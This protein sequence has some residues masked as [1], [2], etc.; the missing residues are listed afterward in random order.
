[1]ESLIYAP[2]PPQDPNRNVTA[3]SRLLELWPGEGADPFLCTLQN[4]DIEHPHVPFEALSYVWGK[5]K[6]DNVLLC[7]DNQG[8]ILGQ[9][10]LT[11]NLEQALRGLRHPQ[12]RRI[13]WIDAICI[14]QD[15]N[16]ERSRQVS[17]M[18]SVY[19][20]ASRVIVWLGEKDAT[21][22]NAFE[23]AQKL[24]MT[25]AVLEANI[26]QGSQSP[27]Q[28]QAA[29][30]QR[31]ALVINAMKAHPEDSRALDALLTKEYFERVWCIQEVAAAKD[32]V[33]KCEDLEIDFGILL[34]VVPFVF[35][36]RGLTP[37]ASGLSLWQAMGMV[38]GEDHD[39]TNPLTPTGSL[40]PML[41]V[42]MS[43][44][45][46][47]ATN[48]VDRIYA[49]LGCT[50][51]GLEPILGSLNTFGGNKRNRKLA[52]MQRGM[53]WLAKNLEGQRRPDGKFLR[54]WALRPDYDKSVRDVY[55]DFTRYCIRRSP[56]VLDALSHVQH[57]SDPTGQDEFPTWVPKFYEPRNASSFVL[58][59]YM[60]GVPP[61]GHYRYF[62]HLQDSPLVQSS[63]KEPNV[64]QADGF[65][66]DVVA[67]VSDTITPGASETISPQTVWN[68]L[69]TMPLSPR[70]NFQY[71]FGPEALDVAFF[72]TL[73]AGG[74]LN[75]LEVGF[76]GAPTTRLEAVEHFTRQAKCDLY[77][78]L[79][80]EPS[81]EAQA[82]P[83][84]IR[85][86][87]GANLEQGRSRFEKCSV[88]YSFNRRLYRTRSGMLGLG[89]M[90][91]KPGDIVV[92]LFGGRYPFLLRQLASE[93]LFLGETYVRNNHI[94][95]GEAV[96]ENKIMTGTLDC[97]PR[98]KVEASADIAGNGVLVAFLLSALLTL[99]AVVFGYLSES[100]PE[101][102]FNEIDL[103]LVTQMHFK[104]KLDSLRSTLA[105]WKDKA[106]FR[107][108]PSPRR[109]KLSRGERQEALT[110]FIL[111]LSDQQLATGFAVLIG[112]IANHSSLTAYDFR[113]AFGLAWF[114]ATT[115]LATLD[116]LRDYFIF[117][118]TVR[119]WRIRGMVLILLLLFY[120]QFITLASPHDSVPM[121]C[122][123]DRPDTGVIAGANNTTG[124]A[125]QSNY[126]SPVSIS[127]VLT[128]FFMLITG[129]VTRIYWSRG[130]GADNVLLERI[131]FRW[132]Y[133]PSTFPEVFDM[134]TVDRT[135]LFR[136]FKLLQQSRRRRGQLERAGNCIGFRRAFY[137]Y[138][139]IMDIYDESFL[140]LAPPLIFMI[141]YGL[142]QLVFTRWMYP[143]PIVVDGGMSFGQITPLC[144][145][146]IPFLAAAETYYEAKTDNTT[147]ESQ[148]E[149]TAD[150]ATTSV[151]LPINPIRVDTIPVTLPTDDDAVKHLYRREH[152]YNEAVNS[153]KV[154]LHA[155]VNDIE[156]EWKSANLSTDLLA[157]L[158]KKDTLLCK[159]QVLEAFKRSLPIKMHS[160]IAFALNSVLC[161]TMG[162]LLNFPSQ[163]GL[164]GVI[165]SV[166][167]LFYYSSSVT[168]S[169]TYYMS[170]V[171]AMNKSSIM[172]A[173]EKIRKV[174]IAP[175]STSS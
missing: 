139:Y 164:T 143:L 37:N 137:V 55:R 152:D 102:Y 153:I 113:I 122:L 78:W 53:I 160:W 10:E 103:A 107:K 6:S 123:Y 42:L 24:V 13:L 69:F 45:N 99:G 174:P 12:Q 148:N 33:A 162:I 159:Y 71:E 115:H 56:R 166:M 131:V 66:V 31:Q 82:Y 109:R 172:G 158:Q 101:G 85:D 47:K 48:P 141:S 154:Y 46:F 22:R 20:N 161:V 171:Q 1:M 90:V 125:A 43:V 81:L 2:L 4:V 157:I 80:G 169:L 61:Q 142:A 49:L 147:E 114:S 170:T 62:A 163:N 67:T 50:D 63:I 8:N 146:V 92:V 121:Q 57:H 60:A 32:C 105:A 72:M 83:D 27:Q 58:E 40:G 73:L 116:A 52:L 168:S 149:A 138:L 79:E 21:V 98:D 65:R 130:G 135:L 112:A 93:W 70:P 96:M 165:G 150:E 145:L 74:V 87:Q 95:L 17:Y 120:C 35:V 140:S 128:P 97:V 5:E 7:A 23:F 41:R 25:A 156:A 111:A 28:V 39:E 86:S 11:K 14:R 89:P 3:Y 117:H 129:Y 44:R 155:E 119:N 173:Y 38:K 94:M 36:N 59:V 134:D 126:V 75:A 26:P 104:N 91:T 76:E 16:A 118:T 30:L 54:H 106:L 124:V 19:N 88:M 34:A 110:R 100:L 18:R 68:Q 15:D 127:G 77:Q 108:Q 167:L 9:L 133:R 132:K 51:E 175:D 29:R 151:T 64:L 136:E 84:L 144:F